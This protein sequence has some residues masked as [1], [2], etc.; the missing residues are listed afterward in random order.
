ML[1]P[2]PS[3]R[4]SYRAHFT[5]AAKAS[6]CQQQRKAQHKKRKLRQW[7][8]QLEGASRMPHAA[9]SLKLQQQ[10]EVS[11]ETLNV[12]WPN[13]VSTQWK[14]V[15]VWVCVCV[16]ICAFDCVGGGSVSVEKG[17]RKF[18]NIPAAIQATAACHRASESENISCDRERQSNWRRS[19]KKATS[20][21][22]LRRCCTVEQKQ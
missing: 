1:V 22:S 12:E 3:L 10:K 21:P 4:P 8:V 2:E 20:W 19:Q 14:T 11:W 16:L 7:R 6:T 9:A 18:H 17:N 13:D 15:C 5:M